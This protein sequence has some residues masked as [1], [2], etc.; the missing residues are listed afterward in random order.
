MNAYHVTNWHNAVFFFCYR[1]LA[2]LLMCSDSRNRENREK[3]KQEN[4]I[5]TFRFVSVINAG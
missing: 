4:L 3:K 2:H 1:V 5:D